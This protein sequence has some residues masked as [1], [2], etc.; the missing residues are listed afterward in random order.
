MVRAEAKKING[1]LK[2]FK[3]IDSK[4]G[5]ELEAIIYGSSGQ[6]NPELLEALAKRTGDI[7]TVFAKKLQALKTKP[8]VALGNDGVRF[9][10]ETYDNIFVEHHKWVMENLANGTEALLKKKPSNFMD[11]LSTAVKSRREGALLL[12]NASELR[13]LEQ[14]YNT[15]IMV[16]NYDHDTLAKHNKTITDHIAARSSRDF[17]IS[18]ELAAQLG[19]DAN[20]DFYTKFSKIKERY[21]ALSEDNYFA[22]LNPSAGVADYTKHIDAV[23]IENLYMRGVDNFNSIKSSQDYLKLQGKADTGAFRRTMKRLDDDITK[24][25]ER[26][27]TLEASRV[28]TAVYAPKLEEFWERL[29]RLEEFESLLRQER[30]VQLR[31]EIGQLKLKMG[32]RQIALD[33]Q[34]TLFDSLKAK[35]NHL[36][37]DM[38]AGKKILAGHRH[39]LA[40]AQAHVEDLIAQLDEARK[41]K[42][43]EIQRIT[44][45]LETNRAIWKKRA[46]YSGAGAAAA[47]GVAVVTHSL[48]DSIWG[49]GEKAVGKKYWQQIFASDKGFAEPMRVNNLPQILRQMAEVFGKKVNQSALDLH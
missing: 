27:L 14:L 32:K 34:Q 46:I 33:K 39:D 9:Y 1:A 29:G 2:R 19:I 8:H 24:A 13:H 18:T 3:L 30:L 37:K 26:L 41:G 31:D 40:S 36:D 6:L 15:L 17:P 11:D 38:L 25:R 47:A 48:N 28:E 49:H 4:L 10:R 45:E 7:D 23:E 42:F 43:D 20:A 21:Q 5:D 22:I 35:H 44:A 16:K 12:D